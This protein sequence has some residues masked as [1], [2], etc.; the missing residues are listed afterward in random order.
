MSFKFDRFCV[1]G[2]EDEL[3]LA[4]PRR[5]GDPGDRSREEQ[6]SRSSYRSGTEP[7][8]GVGAFGGGC[9]GGFLGV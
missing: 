2:T 7:P 5:S 9:G 3:E 1:E 4:L 6:R 8:G